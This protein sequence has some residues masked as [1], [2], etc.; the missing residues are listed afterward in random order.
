MILNGVAI[1]WTHIFHMNSHSMVRLVFFIIKNQFLE[2]GLE[3]SLIFV[4][5]L[6]EKK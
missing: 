5:F 4:L 2:K 1:L 3:S 6:N